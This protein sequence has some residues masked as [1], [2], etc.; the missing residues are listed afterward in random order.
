VLDSAR[1]IADDLDLPMISCATT[2]S[3]MRG[4]ARFR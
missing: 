3:A 4:A 1:A 2:A